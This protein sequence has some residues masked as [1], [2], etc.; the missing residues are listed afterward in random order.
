MDDTTLPAA[1]VEGEPARLTSDE[2]QRHIDKHY[3]ST[4][5]F[6]RAWVPL[7]VAVRNLRDR[8]QHVRAVWCE[9]WGGRPV[10]TRC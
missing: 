6:L 5:A 9:M 3:G 8:W 2:L 10:R 4:E 7:D 1:P